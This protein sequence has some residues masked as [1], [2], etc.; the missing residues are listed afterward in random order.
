MQWIFWSLKWSDFYEQKGRS[1]FG[2][3]FSTYIQ[4]V[5]VVISSRVES[6]QCQ[7]LDKLSFIQPVFVVGTIGK[8]CKCHSKH[9]IFSPISV[10]EL[11]YFSLQIRMFTRMPSPLHSNT[12]SLLQQLVWLIRNTFS[13]LCLFRL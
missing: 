5:P 10:F 6:E 13:S 8:A 12:N 11:W 2:D 1:F 7:V 9:F 4:C 3:T